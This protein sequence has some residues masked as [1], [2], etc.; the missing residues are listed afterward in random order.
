ML[1][2]HKSYKELTKFKQMKH[3]YT[4]GWKVKVYQFLTHRLKF[5][6]NSFTEITFNSY[7]KRKDTQTRHKTELNC[8]ALVS[9]K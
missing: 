2:F 5:R 6:L 8:P 1:C 4:N 3:A 7:V 9:I